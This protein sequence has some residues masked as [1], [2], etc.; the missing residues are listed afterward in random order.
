MKDKGTPHVEEE[1][2]AP[3]QLIYR[4]S[5]SGLQ[6][7]RGVPPFGTMIPHVLMGCVWKLHHGSTLSETCP[8]NG[9]S[10]VS[11]RGMSPILSRMLFPSKLAQLRESPGGPVVRAWCFHCWSPGLIPGWGTKI[12]QAMCMVWLKK[13]E[14]KKL[15]QLNPDAA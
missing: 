15:E 7:L 12:P 2:E 4:R 9:R 6:R 8:S 5:A 10:G 14:R 11:H 13:K 3:D 1:N